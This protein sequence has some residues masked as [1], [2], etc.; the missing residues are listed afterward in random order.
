[1][2]HGTN[3]PN[4]NQNLNQNQNNNNRRPRG[5]THPHGNNKRPQHNNGGNRNQNYDSNG[6][7]GRIRGT[8]KQIF[9]KYT[10]MAKDAISAGDRVLVE[11]LFQF[12]DHYG[13]I[14]ALSEPKPRQDY[15][16]NSSD[17]NGDSDGNNDSSNTD[18]SND[19]KVVTIT[20][21]VENVAKKQ[22]E[23]FAP[24]EEDKPRRRTPRA[25]PPQRAA[26]KRI[27]ENSPK[28]GGGTS[29]V[30]DFLARP[31][32]IEIETPKEVVVETSVAEPAAAP[33]VAEEKPKR[34]RRAAAP[35]K[36]PAAPRAPRRKKADED[37]A[38]VKTDTE[39]V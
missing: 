38:V 9:E 8:A 29:A 32:K 12:A 26:R 2:R 6:P 11:S 21:S 36:D 16:V 34:T 30:P 33:A 18:D 22:D 25:A 3:N 31:V 13:R 35:K 5:R 15:D 39:T 4:Q 37:V 1:M 17:E 10:Q 7:Q 19:V 24:A 20:E 23:L 14:A 27:E 28:L